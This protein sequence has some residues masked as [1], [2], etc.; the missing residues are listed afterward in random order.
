M[1]LPFPVQTELGQPHISVAA[2]NNGSDRE[3]LLSV[4]DRRH[5]FFPEAGA[6]LSVHATIRAQNEQHRSAQT[7]IA[8]VFAGRP[9]ML[10]AVTVS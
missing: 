2:E 1:I 8:I 10:V 3:C 7:S 4:P 5:Q 9:G 6:A